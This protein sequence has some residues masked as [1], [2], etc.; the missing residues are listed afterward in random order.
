ES[1]DG[2]AQ[3]GRCLLDLGDELGTPHRP[4]VLFG[5]KG[6]G[7]ILGRL[8]HHLLDNP[9]RGK[10]R[11]VTITQPSASRADPLSSYFSSSIKDATTRPSWTSA[12][13]RRPSL[14]TPK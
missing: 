2:L 7:R 13:L 14:V 5:R 1:S 12:G 9:K 8:H 10:I 6:T 3:C 11:C 4:I